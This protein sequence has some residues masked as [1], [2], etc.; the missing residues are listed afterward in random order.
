MEAIYEGLGGSIW[1]YQLKMLGGDRE[2][3][4]LQACKQKVMTIRGVCDLCDLCDPV[5]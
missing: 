5:R 1:Q 2:I 3:W 4:S